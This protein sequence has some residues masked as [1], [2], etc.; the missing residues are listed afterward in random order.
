[1][2]YP[3]FNV[4]LPQYF[5]RA[6]KTGKVQT[7]Y[8]AYRNYAIESVLG[9][10]GSFLGAYMLTSPTLGAR[11]PSLSRRSSA[12]YFCFS[13]LSLPMLRSHCCGECWSSRPK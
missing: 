2:E 1:M 10:P 8:E 6:G 5:E 4:F 11:K 13:S 7:T 12:R 3:L 9:V